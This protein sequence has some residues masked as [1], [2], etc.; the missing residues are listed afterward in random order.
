MAVADVLF[1]QIPYTGVCTEDLLLIYKLF[2][3]SRAEYMAV[4]WHSSLN[5]HQEM[6]VENIQITSLKII[7]Q[8]SFVSY[9]AALEM[10][11]LS[12]LSLRRKNRCLTF[13]KR[14]C[15]NS[16]SSEMFPL[17]PEHQHDVR[18]SEKYIVN[19]AH[20][21]SYKNSAVPYCQRLLNQ[22]YQEQE[23]K[24]KARVEA[25][26]KRAKQEEKEKS[27]TKKEGERERREEERRRGGGQ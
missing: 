21:E 14:C 3:R 20:T 13:A 9:P 7:L 11:G 23:E 26:K 24:Q 27:R 15:K 19:F 1:K 10:T 25:E 16:I 22:D 6:K 17:N 4:L 2:I 5:L 18:N 12:E 8:E